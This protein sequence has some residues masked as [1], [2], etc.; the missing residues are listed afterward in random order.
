MNTRVDAERLQEDGFDD[1][2][3]HRDVEIL[4]GCSYDRIDDQGLH[5]TV[6]DRELKWLPG[7]KQH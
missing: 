1:V 3:K 4:G 2:L 7:F 5:I 6:T